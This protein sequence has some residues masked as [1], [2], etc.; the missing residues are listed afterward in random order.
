M[1]A[2]NWHWSGG[3]ISRGH[4][5]AEID[6]ACVLGSDVVR[7]HISWANLE[8][9]AA[10]EPNSLYLARLDAVIERARSCG[11]E[12]IAMLLGT[13]CWVAYPVGVKPNCG[14]SPSISRPPVQAG[15][16]KRFSAFLLQRY[17]DLFALEI[18]NEPNLPLFFTGTPADY[19]SM[20]AEA[21]AARRETG[22]RTKIIAGAIAGTDVEY[23]EQ[24]YD[25]GLSGHDG[26]SIHPYSY[27]DDDGA[28][29]FFDPGKMAGSPKHLDSTYF[30]GVEA[31]RRSMVRHGE[32]RK[33]MWFTEFGFA[34]CPARPA[35]GSEQTQ[36]KWLARSFRIAAEQWPFVRGLTAF[37]IRDL[38][39][40]DSYWDYHFG[41][42]NYDFTPKAAFGA[43]RKTFRQLRKLELRPKR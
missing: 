43:V 7:L 6:R 19:V 13:P 42:L 28:T 27:G 9:L 2:P 33:G 32:R 37:I 22:S 26:I 3:G 31:M 14:P 17:P 24:L 16:L 20:V 21:D 23:L 25:A 29:R 34:T 38:S 30:R 5:L 11:I 15:E 12:V 18:W 35:C 36:A 1:L 40:T 39:P 4:Q 10:G 8:P 41:L